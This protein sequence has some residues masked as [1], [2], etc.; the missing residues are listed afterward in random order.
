MPQ[1]LPYFFTNQI[2][3]AIIS[4]FTIIFI[5]SRYILPYFVQLLT[6]RVYIRKM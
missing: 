6:S 2:L 5:F 3:F 4:L 1:L